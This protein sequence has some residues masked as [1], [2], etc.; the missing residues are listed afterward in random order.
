MTNDAVF[1]G[2]VPELYD[3]H[4]GPIMFEPFA[5]VI[6]EQLDRSEVDILETAAGTGIVT[7]AILAALPDSTVTATD[8]TRPCWTQQPRRPR[9][10][11]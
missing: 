11:T 9:M 8:L 2:P 7:R 6:A 3:R 5:Q 10:A 4:L 1:A